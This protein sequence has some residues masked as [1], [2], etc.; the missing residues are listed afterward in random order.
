MRK[1]AISRRPTL[2]P[3][4]TN[5]R[6]LGNNI[7]AF[8]ND[9]TELSAQA[10]AATSLTSPLPATVPPFTTPSLLVQGT[11]L[12]VGPLSVAPMEVAPME[13]APM[14]VA[15]MEVAPSSTPVPVTVAPEL[16]STT[17]SSA[18]GK[19][20][21]CDPELILKA[22]SNVQ[23][24]VN[25]RL[26]PFYSSYIKCGWKNLTDD[27]KGKVLDF[28]DSLDEENRKKILADCQNKTK[29]LAAD[30]AIRSEAVHKNDLARILH[31]L[32]FFI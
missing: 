25:G 13:V 24:N 22:L 9:I 32:W 4:T 12:T 15:P 17:S 31:L 8:A 18:H 6:F 21:G 30:A 20:N 5:Q 7:S 11:P 2:G 26:R 3:L 1:S 23:A 19:W 16:I 27:Q 28:F 14:E 29:N 10:S